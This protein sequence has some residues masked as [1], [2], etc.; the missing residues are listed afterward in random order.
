MHASEVAGE[1]TSLP[2]RCRSAWRPW[3]RNDG[4]GSGDAIRRSRWLPPGRVRDPYT[5]VILSRG[6]VIEPR[7]AGV[8]AGWPCGV[9]PRAGAFDAET[10]H[11]ETNVLR[12]RT[13]PPPGARTPPGQPAGRRRSAFARAWRANARHR[14]GKTGKNTL[15]AFRF[16]RQR[17]ASLIRHTENAIRR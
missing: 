13:A 4:R 12:A 5:P 9:P 2:K 8:P 11:R 3:A 1:K 7:S 17:V 14:A 16:R 10:Q 15:G 6:A